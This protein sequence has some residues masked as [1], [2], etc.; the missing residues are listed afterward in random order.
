MYEKDLNLSLLLD[1]YGELLTD[2]QRDAMEY[3]YNEDMSLA[4]I[5]EHLGGITRQGVRDAIKRGEQILLGFE[6]KLGLA[7]KFEKQKVDAGAILE[8]ADEI[9]NINM[10]RIY[11]PEIS[12][13]TTKIIAHANN[14][15][16]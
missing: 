8:L 5:S 7:A 15:L 2:K 13:K 10:N 4:E 16:K 14:I 9:F 12:D 11:N 1:F 3:Y 6:M